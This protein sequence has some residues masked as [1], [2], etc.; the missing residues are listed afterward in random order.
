[1]RCGARGTGYG[2]RLAGYFRPSTLA[3]T[4]DCLACLTAC[5]TRGALEGKADLVV[6]DA[7]MG[8]RLVGRMIVGPRS[9]S[10]ACSAER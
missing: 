6:V 3:S 10:W 7:D 5:L 2:T 1:M 8:G 4:G 9:S